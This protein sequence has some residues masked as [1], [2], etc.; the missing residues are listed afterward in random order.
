[1][2]KEMAAFSA[3]FRIFI[4]PN[5]F[6]EMEYGFLINMFIG[7]P[8]LH[9]LVFSIVGIFYKR[10]DS[11][12]IGSFMYLIVYWGIIVLVQGIL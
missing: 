5:P 12:A 8:L 10:G 7:E 2:Y 6:K 4:L 3:F 9:M 1:M 11:P